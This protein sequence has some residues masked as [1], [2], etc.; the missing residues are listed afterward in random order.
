[1]GRREG[2]PRGRELPEGGAV[3]GADGHARRYRPA[4]PG[5]FVDAPQADR[6]RAARGHGREVRAVGDHGHER[7]DPRHHGAAR[8]AGRAVEGG[9]GRARAQRARH[10]GRGGEGHLRDVRRGRRGVR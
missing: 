6:P 2:V 7:G 4:E 5:G 8:L 10:P 3:V 1:M 9:P